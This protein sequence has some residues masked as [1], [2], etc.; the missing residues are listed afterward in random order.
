MKNGSHYA[1]HQVLALRLKAQLDQIREEAQAGGLVMV[2]H[3][4]GAA[5]EAARDIIET[6]PQAALLRLVNPR[7]LP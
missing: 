2:A 4:A 7:E 3:L 5:A 1:P 6:P